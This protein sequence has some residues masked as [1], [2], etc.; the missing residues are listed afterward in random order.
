MGKISHV[1]LLKAWKIF[2]R[3]LI[4]IHMCML[5]I[6]L[7]F[8]II[9][10]LQQSLGIFV[11]AQIYVLKKTLYQVKIGETIRHTLKLKLLFFSN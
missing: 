7:L 3:V 2:S 9:N 11:S 5:A 1:E 10:I 6:Y 4:G 8:L